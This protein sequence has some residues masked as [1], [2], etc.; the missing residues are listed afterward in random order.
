MKEQWVLIV[1]DEEAI[2]EL[3][4]ARLAER[5]FH[6][7]SCLRSTDAVRMLSNQKF[8]CVLL[9]MN[10]EKGTG[11]QVVTAVRSNEASLNFA[12][13]IVVMS[14]ALNRDIVLRIVVDAAHMRIERQRARRGEADRVA[15]GRRLRDRIDADAAARARAVLHHHRGP[16]LRG[17]PIGE[18]AR[19]GIADAAGRIGDDQPSSAQFREEY[20]KAPTYTSNPL[21]LT[22]LMKEKGKEK[23]KEKAKEPGKTPPGMD[24]IRYFFSGETVC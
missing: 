24:S 13:P 12:T 4:S 10:L 22:A 2:T 1:E 16:H 14:G 19:H 17:E 5:G 18:R 6:V 3:L 20:L 21:D 8:C 23:E 7:H 11:E 9:D 15:I